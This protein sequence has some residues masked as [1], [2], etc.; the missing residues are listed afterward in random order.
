MVSPEGGLLALPSA[1]ALGGTLAGVALAAML[2]LAGARIGSALRVL[3][4]PRLVPSA[5]VDAAF[6]LGALGLS[7]L[8]LGLG[9]LLYHP[10]L[11]TLAVAALVAPRQ[12]P[13]R[14]PGPSLPGGWMGAAW[15]AVLAWWVLNIMNPEAGIDAYV[16][17]LRLPSF[18]LLHHRVFGVWHQVH[19]QVPQV[20]EMLVA[21]LPPV[22]ADSGAQA[23]STGAA[24]MALLALRRAATGLRPAPVP[25]RIATLPAVR[26]DQEASPELDRWALLLF[27]SP[28]LVGIGT[29]AYSDAPLVWLG[30]MSLLLAAGRGRGRAPAAGLVLG[31]ACSVKY[32]AFPIVVA[33]GAWMAWAL[34]RRRMG[35]SGLAAFGS[36]GLAVFAPW[37]AWNVLA[38]GN[39]V[40]PFLGN[41]FPWALKPSSFATELGTGVF[42]RGAA[43]ILASPWNAYVL[44]GAFLFLSPWFAVA[45]PR[46]VFARGD[47]RTGRGVWLASYLAAWAVFMAD[48]RF[49][50]PAVPVL[51]AALVSAGVR[52]PRGAGLALLLALNAWG[53]VGGQA[54]PVTRMQ[55][56]VGL[57]SRREYLA[58][59][60]QPS[61]GYSEAAAWIN[62]STAPGD[63]VLFV[64]ECRSHLVWRE[65]IHEHVIDYP[66]RLSTILESAGP[67]P[68]AIGKRFRQLGVRWVL[69]MPGNALS[70]LD[71]MPRLFPFNPPLAYAWRDLWTARAVPE[72][73]FG[74]AIVYRLAPRAVGG[75]S[76]RIPGL[77]GVQEIIALSLNRTAR[78]RGPA[79]AAREAGEFAEAYP[80]IEAVASLRRF[81]Q[82]ASRAGPGMEGGPR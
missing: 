18:Y 15:T 34:Y 60:F 36:S 71:G 62:R 78:E 35:A 72:A 28:L 24:L 68:E 59:S 16:Y 43:A 17:H 21:F 38:T 42:H 30:S 54:V 58:R 9:G 75:K 23:L 37:M 22:A 33:G 11:W 20:W 77:P 1:E 25:G 80:G 66:S 48:E 81:W 29:S 79:A 57:G 19:G 69:H 47:P 8:G 26:L 31:L 40:H 5:E 6:G 64:A 74:G 44:S 50:L 67:S 12:G 32:A 4:C 56:A 45:G 76:R 41:L 7:A 61:P 55:A 70:R 14:E 13:L 27:S 53:T 63:R 2:F 46:L 10:F 52:A 49:A 3:A 39:P 65:C 73:R 82:A 51:I